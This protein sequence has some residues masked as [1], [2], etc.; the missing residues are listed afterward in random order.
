[1]SKAIERL[2][3]ANV[4]D[5]VPAE[6]REVLEGLSDEEVDALV[7]VSGKLSDAAEVAGFQ[8][9][10]TAL[11]GVPQQRPAAGS[12]GVGAPGVGA[13]PGGP[14]GPGR[15]EIATDVGGLIF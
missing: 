8:L 15:S 3:A 1:M 7:S 10:A 4:L 6:L 14:G 11:R 5:S 13:R 9:Q 2:Q 12:L